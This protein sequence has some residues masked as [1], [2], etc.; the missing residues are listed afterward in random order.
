MDNQDIEKLRKRI[1]SEP[2]VLFLGQKYLN[3]KT[4]TDMFYDLVNDGLCE[5]KLGKETD[6]SS[7]WQAWNKENRPTV[8]DI[9]KMNQMISI[10]PRQNWL[11]KVIGMR[12]GMIMTSAIDGII[13]DYDFPFKVIDMMQKQF[14]KKYVSKTL[15]RC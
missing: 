14:S 7:L 5:G 11:K 13:L 6:Y 9:D 2:S 15:I 1:S 12:W 3:S 4:G 8:D 10:I